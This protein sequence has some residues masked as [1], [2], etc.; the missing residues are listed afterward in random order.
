MKIGIIGSGNIGG[1]LG[2]H[3][4][5]AG[6]SVLF[7]S[8]HPEKLAGLVEK[9]GEQSCAGKPEEAAKYGEVVVL[10]VPFKDIESL[11]G[12]LSKDLKGKVIIDTC[13]PY[14]E[15]DGQVAQQV[16]NDENQRESG[17]TARHFSESYVVKAFNTVYYVNLK[18]KAFRAGEEQMAVPLAGDN[19]EAR[20][21]V[22]GLISDIGFAPVDLG[23]LDR[24]EPME[25]DKELYAKIMKRG[26]ML[27]IIKRLS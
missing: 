16:R 3:L 17:Y 20:K 13:N 19:P 25:V 5:R 18:E 22:A 8:R 24:S 7:S 12:T 1:N 6:H 27:N 11:S 4:A 26:E 2:L 10:S 23:D 9:A 21:K 15:R 14:P